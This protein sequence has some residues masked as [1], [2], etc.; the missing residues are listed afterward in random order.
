MP[1]I[2]LLAALAV[3]GENTGWRVVDVAALPL[4]VR[5]PEVNYHLA[6][7]AVV[8]QSLF[9]R[10]DTDDKTEVV[11]IKQI[12]MCCFGDLSEIPKK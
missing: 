3:I 5:H 9:I 1:L 6:V 2:F 8:F 12:I 4:L 10:R 11:Q 7:A